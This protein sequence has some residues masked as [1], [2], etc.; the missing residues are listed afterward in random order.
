M[1]AVCA[2]VPRRW[3]AACG[4][5]RVLTP[6]PCGGRHACRGAA[7][8]KSR[9]GGV[10]SMSS[11]R[12]DTPASVRDTSS[13]SPSSTVSPAPATPASAEA[14]QL[15]LARSVES[16]GYTAPPE[17]RTWPAFQYETPQ[18]RRAAA[19]AYAQLVRAR[20]MEEQ[21]L[22]G[23]TGMGDDDALK[24]PALPPMKV[25]LIGGPCSGKGTIAPML[26]QTFRTRVVGAGQLLRAAVRAG[27]ASGREA[28]V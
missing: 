5:A 28:Q 10:A 27:S 11:G 8:R 25:V 9:L 20:S 15:P 14:T 18:A 7:L 19:T 22:S 23:V 17:L 4:A 2:Q 1:H 3:P 13:L 6:S 12:A 24:V 26:S 16:A 21:A